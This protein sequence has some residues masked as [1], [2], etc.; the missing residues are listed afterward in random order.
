MTRGRTPML[1]GTF[2]ANPDPEITPNLAVGSIFF[3][4]GWGLSG[5]CPGPAIASLSFGGLGGLVFLAAM[6][7]GMAAAP[8]ARSYLD[9]RGQAA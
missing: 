5:L 6:L 3:G 7:A 2:P 9:A 4:I 1:G 8:T